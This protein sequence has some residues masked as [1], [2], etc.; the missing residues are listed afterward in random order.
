MIDKSW[1]FQS[2]M[3]SLLVKVHRSWILLFPRCLMV[4]EITALLLNAAL[5]VTF[6][7]AWTKCLQET[8]A[9]SRQSTWSSVS[10]CFWASLG[11]KG[12]GKKLVWAFKKELKDLEQEKKLHLDVSFVEESL[13]LRWRF[14]HE[15][16]KASWQPF[17]LSS[18]TRKPLEN[19]K[20]ESVI[21]NKW[22]CLVKK[23]Y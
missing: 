12:S 3:T 6:K 22:I 16:F 7:H 1:E 15:L 8:A 9:L 5:L 23:C 19:L 21:K 18:L 20:Y 13:F 2:E 17:R 11:R 10:N 14:Q 4:L